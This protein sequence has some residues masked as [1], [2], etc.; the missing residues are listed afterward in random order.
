MKQSVVKVG[1]SIYTVLQAINHEPAGISFVTDEQDRLCG[2]LTDGDIRRKLLE[3]RT[4][5][6][7]IS[8]DD[9]SSFVSASISASQEELLAKTNKKVRIIP[10]VDEDDKLVDY[11]RY[12]HKT[13]FIPVAEPDLKGNELKYLTDAF[14]ST[15]ISSSGEYINRFEKDFAAYCG[16]N[17]AV[18]VSNGTVAIHLA[19][20]ALDIGEGDE[21]IIPDLTFAATINAVII[22]NATPVIVDILEDSWTIDPEK[23]EA[24]ITEKTKA[25]IPVH[26]YGQPCNMDSIMSIA[27]RNGL[28]V[29]EDAAEAHGAEYHG[30]KVGS[31]GHINTF[32]FF[33]NKVITTGEG[34]MCTTNDPI[35]NDRMRVLRDHGMNKQRRYWHDEIG[36]NYRMT[37]LQAA[38]GCAQLERIDE[39]IA[40]RESLEQHYKEVLKE[41]DIIWQKDLENCKRTVWLVSALKEDREAFREQLRRKGIDSRPFFYPL[42]DME[43]YSRYAKEKCVVAK[44]ISALGFNLP[45]YSDLSY[46][47]DKI[48]G[49]ILVG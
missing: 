14:V 17:H 34:G 28:Y 33:A 6:S 16:V 2:V 32:S 15:W 25:I 45:T 38:I 35:L 26:I 21:V 18:A 27:D 46:N 8:K 4:I 12:E 30:K 41:T 22:A 37:N 20:K 40:A 42:S 9:L 7:V 48:G 11:F 13:H 39:I 1:S 49:E 24:A 36:F 23:I 19:L 43:I 44:K 29:I 31:F 5:D 47:K 10:L 3:G